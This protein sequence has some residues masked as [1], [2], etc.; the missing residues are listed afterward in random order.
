MTVISLTN[1]QLTAR[2]VR[3]GGA[4][5]GLWWQHADLGK[6]ALLRPTLNEQAGVIDTAAYPLVPFGNRLGANQFTLNDKTHVFAANYADDPLYIHGDGW[7]ALWDIKAQSA[8][9]ATLIYQ[10]ESEPYC[11]EAE[12]S[13]LLEGG[14]FTVTLAVTNQGAEPLPFGLGWHPFFPL[15]PQTELQFKAAN[16]WTEG[17]GSLP[18]KIC[19]VQGDFD[20][21]KKRNIP[22][23]WFNNG[24]SDWD[25]RAVINWPESAISMQIHADPIFRHS[26]LYKP[27]PRDPDHDP[28]FCFEPMTHQG[29]AHHLENMGDLKILKSGETLR[30][31]VRLL[32]CS[33][34]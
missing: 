7:L 32:P 5:H 28:F 9:S 34:S 30:G 1:G 10:H 18:D 4:V 31:S 16:Y 8:V 12:Q 3:Q 20:F 11:Y 33:N 17:A 19:P 13:F 22:Q 24:F 14:V 23:R 27:Y 26:F 29:N 2:I 15:T 6:I 25:G 21:T